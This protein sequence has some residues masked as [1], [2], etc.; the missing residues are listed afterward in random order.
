MDG[1]TIKDHNMVIQER[2]MTSGVVGIHFWGG[3]R[4]RI[5]RQ[6]DNFSDKTKSWELPNTVLSQGTL[7]INEEPSNVP[8]E[9]ENKVK[10]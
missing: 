2:I 10:R 5:F 7:T 1:N 9:R 8:K 3:A 4:V 6:R